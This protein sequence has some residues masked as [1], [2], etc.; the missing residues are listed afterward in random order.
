MAQANLGKVMLTPEGNYNAATEYARLDFVLYNGSSWVSKVDGNIGHTPADGAYWQELASSGE[1]ITITSSET[2]YAMQTA[3]D[4]TGD[5]PEDGW[6][7]TIPYVAGGNYLWTRDTLTFSDGTT[8]I[9][10]LTTRYGVDGSGAVSTVNGVSPDATGNVALQI[11]EIAQV[12]ATPQTD[13]QNL[14]RSGG[15]AQA[16]Y[17]AVSNL[18]AKI[19]SG[20][21][22]RVYTHTGA[23]QG[24]LGIDNTPTASSNNLITSGGVEAVTSAQS[25]Q[26]ETLQSDKSDKSVSFN[27]TLD[28]DSWVDG[29]QSITDSR[30]VTS[31]F[32]YIVTPNPTD[33]SS[34]AEAQIYADDVTVANTMTFHAG[35]EPTVDISV[36]ILKVVS[37]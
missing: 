31:G 7:S 36:S 16:I 2:D 35:S 9:T 23:T 18:L 14:V 15:V 24:D 20:A 28:A 1:N 4:Y 22:T 3:E 8:T 32:T 5:P 12:D 30:F 37:I 25:S 26:I 13:S 10:Y 27:V 21:G 34:Y 33:F 6:Q 19:T 17:S 29:E 11:T